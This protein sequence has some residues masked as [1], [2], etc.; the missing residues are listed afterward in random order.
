[1]TDADLDAALHAFDSLPA[2]RDGMIA[3]A[4]RAGIDITSEAALRLRTAW[5]KSWPKTSRYFGRTRSS[6]ERIAAKTNKRGW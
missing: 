2:P 1:M 5:A 4:E 3:A 6:D